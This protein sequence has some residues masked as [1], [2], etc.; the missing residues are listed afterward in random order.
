MLW[1]CLDCIFVRESWK[2]QATWESKQRVNATLQSKAKHAVHGILVQPGPRLWICS[3]QISCRQLQD[4]CATYALPV[5]HLCIPLANVCVG[6]EDTWAF[7]T[8]GVG[9]GP[10]GV[11]H[12]L[13]TFCNPAGCNHGIKNSLSRSRSSTR[14]WRRLLPCAL[15]EFLQACGIG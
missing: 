13:A 12:L 14:P 10:V 9:F 15:R 6:R 5:V 11:R 7:G 4:L 1:V 3:A 2:I 8:P